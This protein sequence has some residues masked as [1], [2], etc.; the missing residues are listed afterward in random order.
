MKERQTSHDASRPHPQVAR[1]VAAEHAV[2]TKPP[3]SAVESNW[4][5]Q[6]VPSQSDSI[7]SACQQQAPSRAPV[8]T[9]TRN[10]LRFLVAV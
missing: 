10:L 5:Q 4:P 3:S 8:S 9:A 2:P 1:R 7:Q 6:A